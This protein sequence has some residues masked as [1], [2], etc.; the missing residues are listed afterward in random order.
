[1]IVCDKGGFSVNEYEDIL[2]DS[3][4]SLIDDLLEP[5]KDADT[6]QVTDENTFVFMQDN[7]YKRVVDV[8]N[9]H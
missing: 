7:C 3:L 8:S 2:Y 6:I 1:M 4:F 5:P 9:C